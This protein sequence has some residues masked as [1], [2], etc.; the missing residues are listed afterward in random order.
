MKI[1]D[2]KPAKELFN[3]F[4]KGYK[5]RDLSALLNLFTQR[6]NMWGTGLDEYRVG[7]KAS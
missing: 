6:I 1:L 2:N 3:Q 4:C 5:N 7:L